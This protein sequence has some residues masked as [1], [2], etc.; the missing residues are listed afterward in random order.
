M[1]QALIAPSLVVYKHPLAL[2][3]RVVLF[4]RPR[5]DELLIDYVERL[6]VPAVDGKPALHI[7]GLRI[8]NSE[9]RNYRLSTSD[10]VEVRPSMCG[11]FDIT[12]LIAVV[13]LA[14]GAPA[15]SG[16]L[17]EKYSLT[18]L[19][20][21]LLKGAVA[22]G[23][24]V[25]A[26]LFAPAVPQPGIRQQSEE[27]RSYSIGAARNATRTWQPFMLVLGEHRVQ[28]DNA[29]TPITEYDG[30][31]QFLTQAFHYGVG[32]LEISDR[33]IGTVSV[34]NYDDVSVQQSD[35][36]SGSLQ[37]FPSDVVSISGA[38]LEHNQG[39]VRTLPE[40]ST[41]VALDF[42]GSLYNLTK[43]GISGS[44]VAIAVDTSPTGAGQWTRLDTINISNANTRPIRQTNHYPLGDAVEQYDIRV[45]K[46]TADKDSAGSF[47]ETNT[48]ELTQVK[49]S[50]PDNASYVGQ[51]RDALRIRAT[52]Q[53]SGQL[54]TYSALCRQIIPYYDSDAS[55]WVEQPTAW[56]ARMQNPAAI[57]RAYVKGFYASNNVR[58]AGIGLPDT[59]LGDYSDWAEFCEDND[60]TCNYVV[61][62]ASHN[63]VLDVVAR[64]GRA[65][66]DWH[67]GKLSIAFDEKDKAPV[68]LISPANIIKDSHTI[69]WTGSHDLA[70]QIVGRWIDPDNEWQHATMRVPNTAT[71]AIARQ[72]NIELVGTTNLEQATKE[73][74]LQWSAN[75]L[76][77]RRQLWQMG[78]EAMLLRRGDVVFM[79][80]PRVDTA[81]YLLAY[82]DAKKTITLS[83]DVD[84][85]G[86]DDAELVLFDRQG[87]T[88]TI[89]I[90]PT[91]TANAVHIKG[92]RQQ[93][94][95]RQRFYRNGK[96]QISGVQFY[97]N[98]Q[99]NK[100]TRV[101]IESVV[102]QGERQ[103][104]ITAVDHLTEYYDA[105]TNIAV[106][107]QAI[108]QFR[109][110]QILDAQVNQGWRWRQG[111]YERLLSLA[112]NVSGNYRSAVVYA[113]T[114]LEQVA[115]LDNTTRA[116]WSVPA[117]ESGNYQIVIVPGELGLTIGNP[118]SLSVRLSDNNIYPDDVKGLSVDQDI[119][120]HTTVR[121]REVSDGDVAGYRIRLVI[122]L[123]GTWENMTPLHSGL[124][125]ASPW[126]TFNL[127]PGT[128]T[129][130]I[131]AVNLAGNESSAA[132]YYT[133]SLN[134]DAPGQA[135]YFSNEGLRDW[136]GTRDKLI[137][138]GS[139]ALHT[140]TSLTW[141]TLPNKWEDWTSFLQ[142]PAA[143]ATYTTQVITFPAR[144]KV[145]ALL[146]VSLS[147]ESSSILE[148]QADNK[149]WSAIPNNQIITAKTLKF[150]CV[151]NT[152]SITPARLS[153]FQIILVNQ[154]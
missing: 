136:P 95:F 90:E 126:E 10:L 115:R 41:E 2:D 120:Q 44:S 6:R 59:L 131:K 20:A 15:L 94:T 13:A 135:A 70:E 28:P 100:P 3:K 9:A 80:M 117:S 118:Y 143:K 139:G 152:N 53:L 112:F 26:S 7:N 47:G 137:L 124:L 43:R 24:L 34:A 144:R 55:A 71:G 129:F 18:G 85:R 134:T 132:A 32:K 36:T 91:S 1:E 122:G 147:G 146:S 99:L 29:A 123:V 142:S 5:A 82:D 66:W 63:E 88:T 40:A 96:W 84:F 128:Y 57:F 105:E 153:A 25:V 141:N 73:M 130:G 104:Q 109:P 150:R 67:A 16:F 56:D 101:K 22:L 125:T 79:S 93:R 48:M 78:M 17:V 39:V 107:E 50:Q 110:P 23:G 98:L 8:E 148:Y 140:E 4:E 113:G 149:R 49:A 72:A 97:F 108:K 116:S 103:A 37:N 46:E 89:R 60:L 64:C 30:D 14:V 77:R 68:M 138:D 127:P 19:S 52:G 58:V 11:D 154:E 45:T 133:V 35:A 145:K 12:S 121:W 42:T 21:S 65:L 83:R 75:R 27:Q 102:W 81:G 69:E 151:I 111:V 33:R 106:V 119:T 38:E 31:E 54:D 74:N 114:P 51:V 61:A 87:D 92:A 76:L 62:D 86:V